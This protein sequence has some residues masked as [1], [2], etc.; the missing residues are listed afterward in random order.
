MRRFVLV[1]AAWVSGSP[2]TSDQLINCLSL[3]AALFSLAHFLRQI[4]MVFPLTPDFPPSWHLCSQ[5]FSSLVASMSTTPPRNCCHLNFLS[6]YQF[7]S[8]FPFCRKGVLEWLQAIWSESEIHVQMLACDP[9]RLPCHH[10]HWAT[11]SFYC[12]CCGLF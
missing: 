8:G 12:W 11:E 2:A 6:C 10:H 3:L 7:G 5:V 4:L 9:A 1:M